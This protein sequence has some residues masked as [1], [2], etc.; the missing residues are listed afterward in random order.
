VKAGNST[1]REI[2]MDLDKDRLDRIINWYNA[3]VSERRDFF[4]DAVGQT[5]SVKWGIAFRLDNRGEVRIQYRS[6]GEMLIT[7]SSPFQ[8]YKIDDPAFAAVVSAWMIA[9]V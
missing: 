7:A 4:A 1:I 2:S 8:A 5:G 3:M 9:P 6:G